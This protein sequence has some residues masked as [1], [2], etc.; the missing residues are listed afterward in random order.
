MLNSVANQG[1]RIIVGNINRRQFNL[2][3]LLAMGL[4]AGLSAG[5]CALSQAQNRLEKNKI[6]LA[7]GG[8]A[9]FYYLPLTI[10]EQ[11]GYFV[12]EG[13][14]LEIVDFPSPIRAQQALASGNADVVCGAFEHLIS[15]HAKQQFVQ[16]FV[17]LGRAPQ[18]AM[19]VSVKNM[20]NYKRLAD[21]KGKRIGIAAP[22]TGTN[23]MANVLLQRAGLQQHDVSYIGVGSSAGALSALRAGQI[24]AICNL[25]PV[26]SQLEQSGE[27]K[28]IADSRTLRGTQAIFGGVMPGACLYTTSDYLQKNKWVVQALSNAIV[29]SLKWLQTAGPKELLQSVP[30][31][32]L[33]GDRGLYLATFNKL[34]ESISLDGLVEDDAAKMSLKVMANFDPTVKAEKIDT[35]K[36][37]VNT[38]AKQSKLQFD[39]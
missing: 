8:K 25:E 14:E 1:S 24:D 6:T 4:S 10:A 5:F 3:S 38:F 39:A 35:S 34:R 13:L 16:S 18:M 28:I 19:G 2:A 17:A 30:E 15:L 9:A 37:Y 22:G 12:A 36:T 20:P 23:I 32:Y 27:I 11:L 29:R 31:V 33:M 26:M 7:V 21:L